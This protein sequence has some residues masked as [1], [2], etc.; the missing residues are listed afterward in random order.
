M[1]SFHSISSLIA[2]YRTSKTMLNKVVR[3]D[4]FFLFAILEGK[5]LFF[6]IE[7]I[8]CGLLIYG[9]YYVDVGSFYAHCLKH[10][11]Y[12]WML[13]FLKGFFCIYW[14]DHIFCCCCLNNL[15]QLEANHFTI[16]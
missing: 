2:V 6:T 1:D 12:K 7:N 9:L 4:P 11:Y 16:L 14:D 3:V 15:F 8:Y 10:F 5:F 13:D